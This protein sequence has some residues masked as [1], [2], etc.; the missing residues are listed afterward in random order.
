[1]LKKSKGEYLHY[2][3]ISIGELQKIIVKLDGKKSNIYGTAEI[4]HERN[5]NPS[6]VNHGL[7]G[8]SKFSVDGV[9]RKENFLCNN[10][11]R[12]FCKDNVNYCATPLKLSNAVSLVQQVLQRFF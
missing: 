10:K 12:T 2:S 11:L 1:M 7:T 9:D 6:V 3:I 5:I 4:L 8:R